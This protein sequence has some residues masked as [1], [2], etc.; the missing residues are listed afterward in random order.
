[1]ADASSTKI[2]RLPVVLRAKH[3]IIRWAVEGSPKTSATGG[4]YEPAGNRFSILRMIRVEE[5]Y[6][7]PKETM[8]WRS[9]CPDL[10]SKD[11]LD[12][13]AWEFKAQVQPTDS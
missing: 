13:Q 9:A 6:G 10:G 8:T 11:A 2:R 7:E 12:F 1:L 3:P 5:L 4:A